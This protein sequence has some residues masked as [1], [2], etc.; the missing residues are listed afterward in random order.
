M[1]KYIIIF[2]ILLL[3]VISIGLAGCFLNKE[4]NGN[5]EPEY[6]ILEGKN[7]EELGLELDIEKLKCFIDEYDL[8]TGYYVNH[9]QEGAVYAG[10][11]SLIMEWCEGN[12]SEL[13]LLVQGFVKAEDTGLEQRIVIDSN[14]Y[15]LAELE[16]CKLYEDSQ[17]VVYDVTALVP[18]KSFPDQVQEWIDKGIP[19]EWMYEV[20]DY[21]MT[22]E[23]IEFKKVQG[24]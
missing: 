12:E 5:K 1:R 23:D 14:E 13:L 17:V 24:N 3:P 18:R 21:I 2:T 9:Y 15:P 10:M 8:S 6:V 19:C 22:Y 20:Y 16:E 7:L 11:S 4:P